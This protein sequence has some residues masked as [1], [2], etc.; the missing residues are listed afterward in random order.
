MAGVQLTT[1][2]TI[3]A[4]SF[5]KALCRKCRTPINKRVFASGKV[6]GIGGPL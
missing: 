1:I 5:S 4:G 3:F 6:G 2:T